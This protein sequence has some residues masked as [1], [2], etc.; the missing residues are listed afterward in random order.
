MDNYQTIVRAIGDSVNMT[1]GAKQT[2]RS[3][4]IERINQDSDS[5][6]STF[7]QYLSQGTGNGRRIVVAPIN[8][9]HPNYTLVGYG[10]FF[11]QPSSQ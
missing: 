11:L 3:A 10:A 8:T 6:S 5:T 9:W 2:T 4:L 1:G 7:S